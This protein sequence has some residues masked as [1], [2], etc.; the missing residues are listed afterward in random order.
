MWATKSMATELSYCLCPDTESDG[1]LS[2]GEGFR[3]L[4]SWNKA[5]R[6]PGKPLT[7]SCKVGIQNMSIW[8]HFFLFEVL[9]LVYS[10]FSPGMPYLHSIMLTY[11]MD[12]EPPAPTAL[13]CFSGHYILLHSLC[14]CGWLRWQKMVLTH[15]LVAR[16][17]I[18]FVL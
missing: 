6:G 12:N 4:T 3:T 5:L 10:L 14:C 15:N 16:C 13:L 9:W 17:T 8:V 7:K 2:G 11:L 18:V 1:L